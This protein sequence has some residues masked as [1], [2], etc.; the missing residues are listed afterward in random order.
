VRE[1]VATYERRR[2]AF[3]TSLNALGV[4]CPAPKGSFFVWMP[5][6]EG[7]QSESFADFL[8]TQANVA[9]APGIGFGPCGDR[10]VRIGLLTTEDR[11]QEAAE[12]IAR[13][14]EVGTP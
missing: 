5:V 2:N 1:L 7:F 10:Y 3:I 13:A 11:L 14:L 8:L 4:A 12:R 9:V 6:P